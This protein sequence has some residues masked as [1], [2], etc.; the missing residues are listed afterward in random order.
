M[1]LREIE[2]VD[3]W[4]H[5]YYQSKAAAIEEL[6]TTSFSQLDRVVDVGAGSAFFSQYLAQKLPST[7]F[8]C[9]DTNYEE[10]SVLI[11]PNIELCKTFRNRK[12]DLYIFMDVLEHVEFDLELLKEYVDSADPGSLVLITVPAF[13][14]LWSEHDV[15]LGHFRRYRRSQVIALAENAGL[16]VNKSNYLYSSLLPIIFLLRKL[17]YR[18]GKGSNMSELPQFAN[19]LLRILHNFEHKY[20]KNSHF[21]LSVVLLATKDS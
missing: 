8:T 3:P 13:M 11:P 9:V 2:N 4:H 20:V 15:Y 16:I 1:D 6:L 19:Y 17:G 5:W 7:Q 10:V 12:A 14:S 21:G 18:N